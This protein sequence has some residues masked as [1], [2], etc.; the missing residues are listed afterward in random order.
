MMTPPSPTTMPPTVPTSPMTPTTPDTTTPTTGTP[1]YGLSPPDYGSMPP[2]GPG[3]G[4]TSPPDYN[5]VGAAA[6]VGQGSAA[7]LAPLCV[8]IATVSLHVSK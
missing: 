7:A 2:P 3:Y 5:D 1:V 4:S 6:T 8:L